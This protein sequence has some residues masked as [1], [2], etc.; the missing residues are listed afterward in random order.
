M[1]ETT[2]KA[3]MN[4]PIPL[5]ILEFDG[6]INWYNNKFYE[7]TG[8]PDLLGEN[9]DNIIQNLDL[10]KVLNE[11]KE[12]YTDVEYKDRQYTVVYNV[13][14]NEQNDNAKYLM[15]LYWMDKTEYLQ[16]KQQYEDDKNVIMLIQVDEYDEVLKSA[17]EEKR[18][19]IT[20]ELERI[21]AAVFE[22]ELKGAIKK[23]SQD[24]YVFFTRE[25][26]LK[27]LQ[28]NKFA[29]LD[30]IRNI[31]QN[32]FWAFGYNTIGIPIAAGLLYIFGGP[33]LNLMFAAAAMS[34]S[35][36]SVV[37]NALR[38]KNF[39]GYRQ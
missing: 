36:V 37:T 3:I 13:I 22:N 8:S 20:V 6:N 38:L 28:E 1:D 32:L 33:L 5:C 30:T 15:M 11:N 27:K 24:K 19:L 18:S 4:L 2:K 26:E 10:R 12:M 7:M 25:K 31:K 35:S 23:T 34:L 29:I 21:F 16:L 14:K 39:K 17:P 9:I